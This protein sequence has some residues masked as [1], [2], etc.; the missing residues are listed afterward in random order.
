MSS[1]PLWSLCAP[2]LIKWFIHSQEGGWFIGGIG[3][4]GRVHRYLEQVVHLLGD[5]HVQAGVGEGQHDLADASLQLT[6][7]GPGLLLG[8]DLGDL[9]S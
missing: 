6:Q 3:W 7:E 4:E 9:G 1:S 5:L 2:T 8:L